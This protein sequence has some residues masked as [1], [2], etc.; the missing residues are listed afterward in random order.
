[1]PG[2]MRF[3]ALS[4]AVSMLAACTFGVPID[5]SGG[6]TG[7]VGGNQGATTQKSKYGNPSSY[8]V[9]GKRYYVLDDARGFAERGIASWY[10]KKFHGRKTSSGEIYNMNAMTAAHKTLPLPTYVRVKNLSNG[11]SVVVKVNDRGPFVGDRIIDL[12]YA[13]A[14]KLD[15]VGPGTARVE[16]RVVDPTGGGKPAVGRPIPLTDNKAADV[17]LYIQMGSFG[18][19]LNAQSMKRDLL[20]ANEKPIT[21]SQLETSSGLFYRVRLGPLYDVDEANA[22][23]RRLN[24][25]GFHAAR[26]VVQE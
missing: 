1:M 2:M 15:V 23:I 18:S 20:A 13:A 6:N 4:L 11:K 7:N 17:P 14:R 19:E 21:V 8:V 25:K 10:G 12:S 9:F 3:M 16:V 5:R 22:I 24:S 26:I